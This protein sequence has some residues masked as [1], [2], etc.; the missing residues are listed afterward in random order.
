MI[1]RTNPGIVVSALLI[2][3]ATGCAPPG[4]FI[5]ALPPDQV[6]VKTAITFSKPGGETLNL[7]LARPKVG[8]G[9][10]PAVVCIY[11]GGWISGSRALM[12]SW[13]EYTAAHGYVAVAP[14]YRLAP[15]HPFPAAVADVRNCV[16]WLR[17]HAKEYNID[18]DHIGAMGLSAGGHLALMLAVTSDNDHFGADDAAP[19]GESARVQAV[20]NYYGPC[21]L[22]AKDWSSLAVRKYLIPFLGDEDTQKRITGRQASPL[23]YIS[24]DDPP[25][26]T[27]QGD[28][29]PTVTPTQAYELHSRLSQ[30][31][32]SNELQV[33]HGLGHGWIDPYLTRT[34]QEMIRFFDR[35]LK[36]IISRPPASTAAS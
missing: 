11:G 2:I 12:R 7:D 5:G 10:W 23:T 22:I 6:E 28:A 14:T 19:N 31:G 32:L 34:Q 9:P 35:H 27:F 1:H 18:P 16:R 13:I 8:Q 4:R 29:D 36:G 33:L 21:D 20:V 25:I 24:K 15:K 26:L 3:L 30:A 17:T